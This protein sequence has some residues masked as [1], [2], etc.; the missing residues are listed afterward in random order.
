MGIK[1][2]IE[3]EESDGDDHL[4][5]VTSRC[6]FGQMMI[7]ENTLD[8]ALAMIPEAI[9]DLKKATEAR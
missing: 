7:A 8:A 1:F 5:F 9:S 2:T 3:V 4:W 6:P